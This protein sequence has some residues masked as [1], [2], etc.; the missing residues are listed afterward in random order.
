[1]TASHPLLAPLSWIS[2]HNLIYYTCAWTWDEM[3]IP[4]S[5][6]DILS[7]RTLVCYP[8]PAETGCP[9][10]SSYRCLRIFPTLWPTAPV[11]SS[12]VD[13]GRD[14]GNIATWIMDLELKMRKDWSSLVQS[15]FWTWMQRSHSDGPHST[16]NQLQCTRRTG[17]HKWMTQSR[18]RNVQIP[19]CP[20]YGWTEWG[21]CIR[22]IK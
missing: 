16:A 8:D 21:A 3:P 1:M 9:S 2:S 20:R 14:R 15:S 4:G 12:F 18:W 10:V 7:I 17:S 19:W 22:Y 13:T 11:M 6:P 5:G